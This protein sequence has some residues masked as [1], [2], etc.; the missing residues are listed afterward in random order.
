MMRAMKHLSLALACLLFT[1]VSPAPTYGQDSCD[2]PEPVCA[3]RASV[4][5]ISAFDPFS[6]AVRI[7]ETR[8]VTNRHSVADAEEVE[9]VRKDGTKV[10]AKVIATAYDGDLIL[11]ETDSLAPGPLLQVEEEIVEDARLYTVAGDTGRRAV[12]VYPPGVVLLEPSSETEHGR[13]H[14]TAYS[15]FGNSGGALVDGEGRLVA[16]IASGGEGRFEAIPVGELKRL[17]ELSGPEFAAQSAQTGKAVRHCI[18]LLETPSRGPVTDARA[19]DIV[20]ACSASANRQLFDLAARAL[21]QGRQLDLAL[22][23]STK[24]VARDPHSL[25]SRLILLTILHIARRYD[26]ELPHIRF[27]MEHLPEEQMVHRFAIQ[28]GKWTDDLELANKGL[29]LVRKHNPAQLQAAENFLKAD[30]PRPKPLP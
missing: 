30:I 10:T 4:Y 19:Q 22:Q 24:A 17:E 16:I 2:A 3:A 9:L 26:D 18:E 1:A 15:Q 5:I 29:D 25:N 27:L 6:S 28:A 11:L 13:L 7:S 20:D 23:L 12:R 8:L 21:G 14:H